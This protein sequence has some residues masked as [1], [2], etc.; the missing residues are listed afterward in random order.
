MKLPRKKSGDFDSNKYVVQ[1][2]KEN[3]VH[4]KVS[5]NKSKPDDVKMM[6]WI[7]EQPE[8]ASGYLKRLIR[9]DMA[10]I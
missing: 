5:L 7:K 1:Y 9:K 6:E 4:V 8:G 3:I 10:Q 2:M